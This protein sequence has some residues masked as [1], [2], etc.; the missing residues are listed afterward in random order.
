VALPTCHLPLPFRW[1]GLDGVAVLPDDHDAGAD[2]SFGLLGTEGW[3]GR[4]ACGVVPSDELVD[5]RAGGDV[6]FRAEDLHSQRH[7]GAWVGYDV[8]VAVGPVTLCLKALG[9]FQNLFEDVTNRFDGDAVQYDDLAAD[10]FGHLQS[11]ELR[12]LRVL[13]GDPPEP[14]HDRSRLKCQLRVG[15][16]LERQIWAQP[17][18]EPLHS[19]D[20]DFPKWFRHEPAP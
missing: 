7:V 4:R 15:D 5:V 13:L 8:L 17:L 12:C 1:V 11:P 18:V 2:G 9:E 10:V 14:Q 6:E 3:D 20:R 19:S 16:V